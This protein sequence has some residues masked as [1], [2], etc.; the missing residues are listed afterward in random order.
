MIPQN[1]GY[2]AFPP[3]YQQPQQAPV[4][5]PAP[6]QPQPAQAPQPFIP[7]QQPPAQVTGYGTPTMGPQNHYTGADQ[8][9]LRPR[10][11]YIPHGNHLLEW[12][13]L[14]RTR[15]GKG[16]DMV[17]IKVKILDSDNVQYKGL[18]CAF[19]QNMNPPNAPSSV[20]FS[21]LAK[22]VF[23]ALGFNPAD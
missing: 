3:T 22:I 16:K 15:T 4:Q 7:Q 9:S 18:E 1:P 10:S 20:A 19:M 2:P 14:E 23:P 5:A 8:A 12:V 21:A 13:K 17:F 11:A 6:W